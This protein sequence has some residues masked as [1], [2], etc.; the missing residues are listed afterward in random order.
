MTELVDLGLVERKRKKRGYSFVLITDVPE[1]I[2]VT[3]AKNNRQISE[4]VRR[5]KSKKVDHGEPA[6]THQN[7]CITEQ[8]EESRHTI[9]VSHDAPKPVHH[10]R[11]DAPNSLCGDAPKLVDVDEAGTSEA[12]E[13]EEKQIKGK[14]MREGELHA[15]KT[16][17]GT[18]SRPSRCALGNEHTAGANGDQ[19]TYAE[20]NEIEGLIEDP[21]ES[22]RRNKRKRRGAD[23]SLVPSAG[24]TGTPFPEAQGSPQSVEF[25]RFDPGAHPMPVDSPESLV[26]RLKGEVEEKWGSRASR[27]F[28][29]ELPTKLRGQITNA[30]IRKYP[31]DVIE[32]MVRLLVWDWEVARG[33]CFPYRHDVP[34]PDPLSFVQ[35]A[36]E[37]ASR[38]E[39]GFDYPS[40]R[41]GAQNSYK[42][43]FIDKLERVDDDDPF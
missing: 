5:R 27:G 10:N 31:P 36:K 43:L 15:S 33:A 8:N 4:K 39:S 21:N 9:S 24:R 6:K 40:A 11:H 35:Y 1:A 28:Q 37:L 13:Q 16:H 32:D 38:V 14:Q 12:D 34:Y 26:W 18:I 2:L 22:P 3:G 20:N 25:Q 41:R 30:V 19:M 42:D 7:R 29:M 17:G 23:K